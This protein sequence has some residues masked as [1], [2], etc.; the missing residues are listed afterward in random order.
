MTSK[1]QKERKKKKRE[2]IAHNRV[3]KRREYLRKQKKQFAEETRKESEAEQKAFGKPKP[4]VK[5]DTSALNEVIQEERKKSMDEV[6][7]K[8]E[9]NLQILEALEQEYDR[10]QELR[11]ELNTKLETEGHVTMKEKMDALHQKALELEGI[12]GDMEQARKEFEEGS[13]S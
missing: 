9:H 7:S 8:I 5:N 6:R 11:K 3:L 12:A 1:K 10:E 13:S 2:E 4:F